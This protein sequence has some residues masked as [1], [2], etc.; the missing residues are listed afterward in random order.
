M[1]ENFTINISND[2]T[3]LL[4]KLTLW[5]VYQVIFANFPTFY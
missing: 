5:T 4:F 1:F 2:Y 3:Q